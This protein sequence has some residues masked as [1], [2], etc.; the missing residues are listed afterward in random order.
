MTQRCPPNAHPYGLAEKTGKREKPLG[1][2]S[3]HMRLSIRTL[4]C[5]TQPVN[6]FLKTLTQM[7]LEQRQHNNRATE[8]N[9]SGSLTVAEIIAS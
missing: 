3:V 7:A 4:R 1:T 8:K 9:R 2:Y 5:N 6:L